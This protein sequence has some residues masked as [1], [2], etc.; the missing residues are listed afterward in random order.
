[1][2]GVQVERKQP[3]PVEPDILSATITSRFGKTYLVKPGDR[4]NVDSLVLVTKDEGDR[5][6]INHEALLDREDAIAWAE[7][8]I[9]MAGG[10]K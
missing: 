5:T 4:W 2:T 3:I 6:K 1:V 9:E 7:A 10:N 8:I